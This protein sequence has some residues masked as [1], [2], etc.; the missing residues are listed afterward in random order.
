MIVG[1]IRLCSE[2]F[3]SAMINDV[4]GIEGVFD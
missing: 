1:T 3:F 4:D 2:G